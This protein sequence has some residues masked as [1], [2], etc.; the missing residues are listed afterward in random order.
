M[1][2]SEMPSEIA[3]SRIVDTYAFASSVVS[4]GNVT[5]VR[6]FLD[7]WQQ[8]TTDPRAGDHAWELRWNS[9]VGAVGAALVL[10]LAAR[11]QARRI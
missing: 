5:P 11:R 3:M 8:S 2:A 4:L 7:D 9:A 10:L 1:R 6:P